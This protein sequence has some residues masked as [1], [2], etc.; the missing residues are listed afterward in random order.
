MKP[1]VPREQLIAFARE[2]LKL[3][4]LLSKPKNAEELAKF[5]KLAGTMEKIGGIAALEALLR[6]ETSSSTGLSIAQ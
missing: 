2:C 3:E 4:D 1:R 5:L 6:P